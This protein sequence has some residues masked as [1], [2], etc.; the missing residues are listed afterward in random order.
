VK[1]A[2]LACVALAF[3]AGACV[4]RYAAP[5]ERSRDARFGLLAGGPA[6]TFDRRAA[7]GRWSDVVGALDS[8]ATTHASFPETDPD[9]ACFTRVTHA[10]RTVVLGRVPPG[11]AVPSEPERTAMR[12]L[13]DRLTV[14]APGSREPLY[15]CSL[16]ADQRRAA[17][18]HNADVLRRAA[19]LPGVYPYSAIVVPG[20]GNGAQA[21]ASMAS[22]LPGEACHGFADGDR[23]LLGS[24]VSRTRRA[25]DAWRGGAA[26][27]VL[28]TGGSFHSP[29]VEAF[30]MLYL[31]ECDPDAPAPLVLVEPCAEH[32]HTNLRNAGR[33]LVAMG[34]R[35]A[36]LVTDDEFQADYFQDWTGMN[37]IGGSVDQRSLRDWG[38]VIGAWRQASVGIEAGF[39]FTP[40]RFWAEPRDGLGGLTCVMTDRP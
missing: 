24:M 36:Y 5:P 34:A 29:L 40:Y 12:T 23:L 2:T 6:A 19:E 15:P 38:Y 22:W 14:D 21:H 3:A 32:T 27:V 10:G 9:R 16:G 25:S 11:C 7:C 28:V 31:L 17:D 18:L 35:N 4:V 26:P 20:F 1:R 33:W 30:A 39:W 37:L 13:A 8:Q